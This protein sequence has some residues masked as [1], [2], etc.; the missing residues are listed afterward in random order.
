MESNNLIRFL[1]SRSPGSKWTRAHWGGL[2]WGQAS[3]SPVVTLPAHR[4]HPGT[5]SCNNNNNNIDYNNT[6]FC[7][8]YFIVVLLQLSQSSPLCPSPPSPPH[9]HSPSPHSCPCLWVI[10]TCSLT[11]PFPF[12]LP[13]STSSP[14]WSLSVCPLF[15]CLW[16]YFAHLFVLLIRFHLKVRSYGICLSPPGLFH[17]V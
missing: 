13:L 11:S 9:S 3:V 5:A 6:L 2:G 7:I 15:P 16:F 14:L 10:H 1:T 17:L 4:K 12:F 8:K